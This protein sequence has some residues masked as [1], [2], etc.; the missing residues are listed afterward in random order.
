MIKVT[1]ELFSNPD[2]KV[3]SGIIAF[4]GGMDSVCLLHWFW[5]HYSSL[6]VPFCAVHVHHGLRG[7]EA[8]DDEAFCRDFCSQRKI[9]YQAILGSINPG[10]KGSVEAKARLL[11][12]EK[13]QA[14]RTQLGYDWIATA[15]HQDDQAETVLLR[16][17]SGS[18]I[19]GLQGIHTAR[20]DGVIRPLL[21]STKEQLEAYAKTHGLSWRVDTMNKD[22]RF[23]RVGLRHKVIPVIQEVFP[24]CS[25]SLIRL[26]ERSEEYQKVI[27]HHILSK[28]SQ[29]PFEQGFRYKR[30]AWQAL[31]E[32]SRRCAWRHF[33]VQLQT[34]RFTSKHLDA[35]VEVTHKPQGRLVQLPGGWTVWHD[36]TWV[37][38]QHVVI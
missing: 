10:S 9:P 23:S 37:Y 29:E 13:L 3:T 2:G 25:N 38:L 7:K 24:D 17:L 21:N 1:D 18:G 22:L 32:V 20:K 31:D 8:D 12:Y 6:D 11:R 27:E 35:L 33:L 34:S 36:R 28:L 30:A 14:L 26:S 16:I 19:E 15:H 5:Q 4:S